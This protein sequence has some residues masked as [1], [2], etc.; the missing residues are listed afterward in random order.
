MKLNHGKIHEERLSGWQFY[1]KL[2]D[3]EM[4]KRIVENFSCV[5]LCSKL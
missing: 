3:I 4:R 1:S 2:N 5:S